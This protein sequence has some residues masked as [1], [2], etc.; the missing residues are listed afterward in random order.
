VSPTAPQAPNAA[1]APDAA[2]LDPFRALVRKI[3]AA[4]DKGFITMEQ[5]TKAVSDAGAPSLNLLSNMQ[6]LIPAV[7]ANIDLLIAM[8]V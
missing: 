1:P 6:H 7:E 3:S 8:A 2:A 4:K 5:V